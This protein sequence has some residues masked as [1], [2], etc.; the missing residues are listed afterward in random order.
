MIVTVAGSDAML[1][2]VGDHPRMSCMNNARNVITPNTPKVTA[3]PAR[4]AA[5]T[6]RS[7][8]RV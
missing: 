8:S 2:P 6:T 7:F 4:M 1:A 3:K 5:R